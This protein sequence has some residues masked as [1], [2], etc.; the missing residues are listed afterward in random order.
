[1]HITQ[2]DIHFLPC[3]L[4]FKEDC[5]ADWGGDMTIPGTFTVVKFTHRRLPAFFGPS[6]RELMRLL[7]FCGGFQVA[8]KYKKEAGSALPFSSE[9]RWRCPQGKKKADTKK[10]PNRLQQEKAPLKSIVPFAFQTLSSTAG[11]IFDV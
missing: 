5:N 7:V 10:N 11:L 2:L 9:P 8:K 4:P 1:M 6:H 3:P